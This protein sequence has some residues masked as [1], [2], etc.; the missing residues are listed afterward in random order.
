MC[1]ASYLG[2]GLEALPT[3]KKEAHPARVAKVGQENIETVHKPKPIQA[4]ETL[5]MDRVA[6]L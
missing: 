1:G 3:K 5:C 2:L 4:A 6:V